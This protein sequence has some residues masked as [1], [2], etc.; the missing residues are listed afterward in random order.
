MSICHVNVF[1]KAVLV[2]NRQQINGVGEL[3]VNEFMKNKIR[4]K[5]TLLGQESLF[6]PA[7]IWIPNSVKD[8]SIIALYK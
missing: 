7:F 8:L 3:N 5:I 1:I 4:V 6:C 2:E